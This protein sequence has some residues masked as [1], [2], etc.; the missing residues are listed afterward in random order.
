MQSDQTPD[1]QPGNP[2][3]DHRFETPVVREARPCG[4]RSAAPPREPDAGPG[5]R[6]PGGGPNPET[7]RQPAGA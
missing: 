4:A 2:Q 5:P 7:K 3:T 6:P 1:R